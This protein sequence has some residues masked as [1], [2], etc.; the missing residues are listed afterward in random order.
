MLPGMVPRCSKKNIQLKMLEY[1]HGIVFQESFH[2][3]CTSEST[4]GIAIKI[5]IK[6]KTHPWIFNHTFDVEYSLEWHSRK[7]NCK[8]SYIL[9]GILPALVFPEYFQ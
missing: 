3:I 8:Y 9:M 2:G 6:I 7:Y 1:F 5:D 4:P